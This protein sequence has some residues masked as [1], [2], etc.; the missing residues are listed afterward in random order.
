MSK[1]AIKIEL[2]GLKIEV[3]GAREDAPR[4]AQQIGKQVGGL[5]QAPA[6]LASGNG[7][8][9]LE[10]EVDDNG[11]GRKTRTP[12]KTG[13][14]KTPADDVNLNHDPEKYSAPKQEWTQAQKAIW[15]LYIVGEQAQ[16]RQLTSYSIAKNFNKYFKASGQIN[17]GNVMKGLE[18]ERLKTPAMVNADMRDGTAKYFL[19]TA[20]TTLGA[21]LSTGEAVTD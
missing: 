14:T 5:L 17:G 21:R 8:L 11:G 15:F 19:T 18:K 4:I 1:F 10:G 20:G 16:I 9:V 3:E 2:Q 6:T 7:N 12:R 13:G